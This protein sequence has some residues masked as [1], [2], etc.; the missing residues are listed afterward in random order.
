MFSDW[1]QESNGIIKFTL[2]SYKIK[3]AFLLTKNT[4][5][6]F[7]NKCA[8]RYVVRYQKSWW[9]QTRQKTQEAD[10]ILIIVITRTE[11]IADKEPLKDNEDI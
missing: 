2:H 3:C 6:F 1:D 11:E 10:G 9:K 7:Y 4:L 8:Y 5:F